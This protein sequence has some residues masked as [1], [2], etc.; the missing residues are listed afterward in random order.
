MD[1]VTSELLSNLGWGGIIA[2]GVWCIVIGRLVPR[3]SVEQMVA[4]HNARIADMLRTVEL[5]QTSNQ[6]LLSQQSRLL[7]LAYFAGDAALRLEEESDGI[8]TKQA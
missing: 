6:K 3:S 5:T 8:P 4:D 7:E 2:G 1:F